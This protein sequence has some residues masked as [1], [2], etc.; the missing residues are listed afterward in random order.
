MQ[1]M[2]EGT[3]EAYQY[4]IRTSQIH[5]SLTFALVIQMPE[6]TGFS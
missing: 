2:L 1:E 4:E 6:T 3:L 5:T